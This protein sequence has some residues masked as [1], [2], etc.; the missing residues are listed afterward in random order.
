L[1]ESETAKT[2]NTY[3]FSEFIIVRNLGMGLRSYRKKGG[4]VVYDP[5]REVLSKEV[6]SEEQLARR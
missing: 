1:F 3:P 4:K 6:I 2:T 5:F